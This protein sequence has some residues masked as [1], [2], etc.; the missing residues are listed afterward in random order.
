MSKAGW[1]K[2]LE[3]DN[4]VHPTVKPTVA[5]SSPDED[6]PAQAELRRELKRS[7]LKVCYQSRREGNS[8]LYVM[9]ADGSNIV[10]ITKT[11]T[12]DEVYPHVSGDGRRICF[13]VVRME[14]LPGGRSVPCFDVY[15]MNLD[16]SSRTLVA[17][18]ATDPC[19]DPEGRRVLFVKRLSREKTEDYQNF[20]LFAYDIY[21][22]EVEGL[23]GGRLYH[24]YVPCWSPAGGWIVA[25]VHEYA[26]FEHAIIAL[27]LRTGK[28]YSL[29]KCGINGCRPDLSW[30]G[31]LICWNPNDIQ[32]CVAPFNPFCTERLPIKVVAQAPP[33]SGS[34]YFGDWSPDGR[35]IA[36][37][38]NPDVTVRTPGKRAL[39]DIFVTRAEGETYVQLTFDHA[40]NKHPEF[41]RPS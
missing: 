19:W 18:D 16:G 28:I 37:S 13:T 22:G 6:S 8:E 40:N 27:N 21:T 38:M 3:V 29:G 39:W 5:K 12:V 32:V 31:K 2:I 41:F 1:L 23:T 34:V 35:Y 4:Q 20:G 33:P 14:E 26:E 17:R 36:Y 11:P 24:A 30:D 9:D 25:T 10:N 7:G 15:W